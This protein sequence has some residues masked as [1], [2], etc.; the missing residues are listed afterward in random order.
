MPN[1]N[2]QQQQSQQDGHEVVLHVYDLSMGLAAQLSMS[3]LGKRIEAIYHTGIVVYGNEYFFGGGIQHLPPSATPYG[4]PMSRI[5]LGRT[6][7]SREAFHQYLDT[8]RR[9]RF[10]PD[11]YHLFENNC[12]HFS[13]EAATFLLG[14]GIPAYIQALPREVLDTPFGRMIQPFIDQMM[15]GGA[16]T[17]S[18]STMMPGAR[19]GAFGGGNPLLGAFGGMGGFGGGFGNNNA[20]VRP[21][22]AAATATTSGPFVDTK[23]K[24]F[25][26]KADVAKIVKKLKSTIESEGIEWNSDRENTLNTLQAYLT[27]SSSSHHHRHHKN[28]DFQITP[29]VFELIA[30]L[31]EKLT[32]L[33]NYPVLDLLRLLVYWSNDAAIE[34]Y[35]SLDHGIVEHTLARFVNGD[36]WSDP[37]QTPKPSQLMILR[38]FCNMFNS[39][40]GTDYLV[41]QDQD[42]LTKIADVVTK[43]YS[44]DQDAIRN[45]A[46]SLACNIALSLAPEEKTGNDA[47]ITLLSSLVYALPQQTNTEVEY[48]MMLALHRL[49]SDNPMG[50]ELAAGL[51]LDLSK[52][53]TTATTTTSHHNTQR[54][55]KALQ[56]ML[57]TAASA[58]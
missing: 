48:K 52:W 33:Q 49:L 57:A 22:A 58:K 4:T 23:E 44:S 21:S 7:L 56:T 24:F 10:A 32:P 2:D 29:S 53:S 27:S 19:A 3:F 37:D 8:L 51:E 42:R 25:Y 15:G 35:T 12:N 41:K 39:S 5:V 50:V 13:H 55:A 34:H 46:A 20:P 16:P 40:K 36:N 54:I 6:K 17:T 18:S 9:G 30:Y 31:L 11:R 28:D 47:E 26:E 43:A 1:N 14:S 38:I 45:T